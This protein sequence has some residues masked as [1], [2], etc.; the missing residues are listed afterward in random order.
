MLLFSARTLRWG[1]IPGAGSRFLLC[2]STKV[3]RGR[4]QVKEEQYEAENNLA[5]GSYGCC[6]GGDIW[7]GQGGV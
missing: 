6:S 1:Y 7:L 5:A 4:L 3:R 2:V